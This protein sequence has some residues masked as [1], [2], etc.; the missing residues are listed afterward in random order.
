M[1]AVAACGAKTTPDGATESAEASAGA[2]D[3]SA[4]DLGDSASGDDV[5][6]EVVS[7]PEADAR[8]VSA[9]DAAT[10]G[11]ADATSGEDVMNEAADADEE[12]DGSYFADRLP[13]PPPPPP[14]KAPPPMR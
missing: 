5:T 4:L 14:Y 1:V 2:G 10:P 6:D 13:P 11:D 8:E 7:P 12:L 3:S 9:Q